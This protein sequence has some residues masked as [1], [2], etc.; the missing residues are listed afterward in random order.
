M[1]KGHEKHQARLD[2]INFHGKDL[3]RRARRKCELCE[4]ADE[5]RPYDIQPNTEPELNTLI[6][7]CARCRTVGDGGDADPRTLR[8]L[9][10]AVWN[11][12]EH[13]AALARTMLARVDAQWARDTLEMLP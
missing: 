3:A 2:A 10:A 13:I 11:E 9:E 1:A 5:L 7:M 8:F 12:H 4:Q 6:L